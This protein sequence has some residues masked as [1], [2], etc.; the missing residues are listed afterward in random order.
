MAVL[1]ENQQLSVRRVRNGYIIEVYSPDNHTGIHGI[2]A[3]QHSYVAGEDDVMEVIR[4]A[5]VGDKLGV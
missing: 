1:S 2:G 4:R 3:T 5:L